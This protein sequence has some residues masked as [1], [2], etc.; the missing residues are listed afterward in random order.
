MMGIT[1]FL[2]LFFPFAAEKKIFFLFLS[3]LSPKGPPLSPACPQPFPQGKFSLPFEFS[4][5][6]LEFS[7][8]FRYN[9]GIFCGETENGTSY[10][11]FPRPYYYYYYFISYITLYIQGATGR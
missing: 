8:Y 1:R 3:P 10:P 2:S 11:H 9:R 5:K 6:M 7:A 4:G